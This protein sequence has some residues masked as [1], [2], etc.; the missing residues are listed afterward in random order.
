MSAFV[1][2]KCRLKVKSAGE[3]C[4]DGVNMASKWRILDVR[5]KKMGQVFTGVGLLVEYLFC[6]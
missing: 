5:I 6:V 1:A 3:T 4:Q 2:G